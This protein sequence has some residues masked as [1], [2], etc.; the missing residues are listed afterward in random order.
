MKRDEGSG[1]EGRI[2]EREREMEGGPESG[3]PIRDRIP[4]KAQ[5]TVHGES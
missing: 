4:E 2:E 1:D 5:R 3:T